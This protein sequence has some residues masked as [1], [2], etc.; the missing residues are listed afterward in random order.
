MT[1]QEP[2]LRWLTAGQEVNYH[3]LAD[4]RVGHREALDELFSEFLAMLE[5]AG[6][7]Y[8]AMYSAMESLRRS[9]PSS[10]AFLRVG[11]FHSP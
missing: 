8:N 10:P 9:P 4:F 7:L 11:F 2:G 3:A 5:R 1:T 6:G